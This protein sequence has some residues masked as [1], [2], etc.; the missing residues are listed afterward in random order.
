[1]LEIIENKF[2]VDLKNLSF[3]KYLNKFNYL[4]ME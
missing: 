1:M 2:L 3:D 4:I